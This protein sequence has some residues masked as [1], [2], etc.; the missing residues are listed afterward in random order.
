MK[1]AGRMLPIFGFIVMVSS[2]YAGPG[3]YAPSK[4][5]PR[6]GESLTIE[7]IVAG[8]SAPTTE[9]IDSIFSLFSNTYTWS[10]P[11]DVTVK[12]WEG[13]GKWPGSYPLALQV[14]RNGKCV[15]AERLD[16]PADSRMTGL[17]AFS[18]HNAFVLNLT[19]K[20]RHN[21]YE[22]KCAFSVAWPGLR[23][24]NGG[25]VISDDVI[26]RKRQDGQIHESEPG[27]AGQTATR[28]ESK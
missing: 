18:H 1:A 26:L 28:S 17:V 6:K 8:F 14:F 27:A 24:V 11:S 22:S 10:L 25:P 21:D 12:L 7:E 13:I 16:F 5:L 23:I 19:C 20:H 15:A 3:P 4:P 2:L 9:T